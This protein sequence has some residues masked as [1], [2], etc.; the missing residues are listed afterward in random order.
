MG[1][2]EIIKERVICFVFDMET[3]LG[4]KEKVEKKVEKS[5]LLQGLQNATPLI[6]KV[7]SLLT[8]LLDAHDKEVINNYEDYVVKIPAKEVDTTE[9]SMPDDKIELFINRAEEKTREFLSIL[10]KK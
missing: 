1:D 4:W 5:G 8:T 10:F 9:F 7:E 6:S 3:P 2:T